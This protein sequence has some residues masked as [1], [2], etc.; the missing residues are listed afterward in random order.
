MKNPTFQNL[1]LT[2]KNYW[3]KKGCIV[4]QPLELEVGA[5]TTHPMTF[6]NSL[7]SKPISAVYIQPSRRPS[8]GRYSKNAYRLQRYFQ[9]QVIIKPPP[10]N[11]QELYLNSLNILGLNIKTYDIRFI[12][13][14]WENPT[15]GASGLGWEIWLNGLEISQITYFQ[16]M[17]GI[18]CFP[19]TVEITYG[20][21][22]I[23]MYM[24]KKYNI[25]DIIWDNNKFKKTTYGDMFYN[26]ELE[27]SRYNF[28][29]ANINFLFNCFKE[30]K[31]EAKKILKLKK[32]LII[33][34]YEYILKTI[35]IFNIL[36]SRKAISSTE[37][38]RYILNIR[39]LSKKIANLYS[40]FY[41]K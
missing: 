1:I 21:E 11:V 35:H 38:Q 15:L 30:Y 6:F 8:D 28:K 37:R 10:N 31:I 17:G 27:Y 12:E 14:N 9:L 34:A 41:L 32:P 29:Y 40:K 5:A 4:I 25:Y 16:Q 26:N 3:Y 24:Q 19:I 33:P 39:A 7:G 13:D 23:A 18:E 20:L 22:R 2:L 36:D